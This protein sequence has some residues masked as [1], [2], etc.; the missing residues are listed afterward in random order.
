[1]YYSEGDPEPSV[2]P[3]KARF[4]SDLILDNIHGNSYQPCPTFY[5]LWSEIRGVMD[6]YLLLGSRH[7]RDYKG[8]C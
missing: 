1:M 5:T 2:K 7:I 6:P 3:I 8:C 4:E